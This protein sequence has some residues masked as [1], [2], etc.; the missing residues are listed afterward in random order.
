MLLKTS[1]GGDDTVV[2]IDDDDSTPHFSGGLRCPQVQ[3]DLNIGRQLILWR[4]VP[5]LKVVIESIGNENAR[6]TRAASSIFCP[7]S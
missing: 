6:S 4:Q 1:D 5:V 7:A 3:H 2:L